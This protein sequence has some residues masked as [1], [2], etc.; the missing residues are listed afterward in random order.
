[1][2]E[3]NAVKSQIQFRFTITR[4][5]K[6]EGDFNKLV[7]KLIKRGIVVIVVTLSMVMPPIFS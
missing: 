6:G 3:F 2:K 4:A 1:M 5:R 7:Y